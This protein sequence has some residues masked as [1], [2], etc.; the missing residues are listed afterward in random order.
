MGARQLGDGKI[1]QFPMHMEYKLLGDIDW[2]R[3]EI[4][5]GFEE[6]KSEA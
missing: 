1:V 6:K 3:V 5:N 4:V 2:R